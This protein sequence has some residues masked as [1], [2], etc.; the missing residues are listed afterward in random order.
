MNTVAIDSD[1]LAEVTQTE[2][3]VHAMEV[4]ID[5]RAPFSV[6]SGMRDSRSRGLNGTDIA[7]VREYI[8]GDPVRNVN[9]KISARI[10]G[11]KLYLLLRETP[12]I[13]DI[14]IVVDVNTSMKFGT[15]RVLKY[16]LAA[17][18]FASIYRSASETMDPVGTI[19][20]RSDGVL[21]ESRPGSLNAMDALFNM[22][23]A[24]RQEGRS[25]QNSGLAN[26]LD[27]LPQKRSIVFVLSDFT[28]LS[29]VDRERLKGAAAIH[30]LHCAIIQDQRERE[31]PTGFGLLRLADMN[32][33]SER[34]LFLNAHT[35]RLY[36]SN[37]AAHQNQLLAFLE[38][39]GCGWQ[40]F[41]TEDALE[42]QVRKTMSLL[43]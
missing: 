26:A 6:R 42:E 34:T 17:E 2:Q 18:I 25:N 37:F 40:I 28:R 15:A 35:R 32:T 23:S 39:I 9:Y 43:G 19:I 27:C 31:L 38:Q 24:N 33:G 13:V 36:A 20:Y 1:L 12:L 30:D 29:D 8:P 11:D 10:P 16:R 21:E 5:W 14:Y 41:S 22:L 4:S 3:R 7:G